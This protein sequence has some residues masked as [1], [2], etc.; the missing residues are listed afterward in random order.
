MVSKVF[1]GHLIVIGVFLS[2]LLFITLRFIASY[3]L[4]G[5]S[6]VVPDLKTYSMTE[7]A[8]TL[9]AAGLRYHIL[10]SGQYNPSFPRG[11]V[12]K[13]YPEAGSR[14]KANREIQLTVNPT[15]PK[16]IQLPDL[17]EKTLR[18]A[19][20]DLESKG[21]RVGKME[22][23]PYI[24]EVV[25]AMKYRGVEV[26]AGTSFESGTVIDLV[27]GQ[28]LGDK[29][30]PVPNLNGFTLKKVTTTL[31]SLYLN[32]GSVVYHQQVAD[33][34]KA[35]VYKQVPAAGQLV[36]MG[37]DVIIWLEDPHTKSPD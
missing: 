26:E 20:Y 21:L 3:T 19:L 18:R 31:D 7:V 2:L 9:E 8:E 25:V 29:K 6:I 35:L 30:I 12:V 13:H 27:V 23:V 11:A 33:S 15:A 24:G 28:G 1:W 32:L 34:L 16:K 14:V 17:K 4:H 5:E 36:R 10:D 37:D 22:F